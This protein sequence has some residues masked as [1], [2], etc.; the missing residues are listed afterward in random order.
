MHN[1]ETT[2]HKASRTEKGMSCVIIALERND[3]L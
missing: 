2:V 3:A 1:S